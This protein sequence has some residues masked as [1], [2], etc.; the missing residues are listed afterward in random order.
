MKILSPYAYLRPRART[1]G[2]QERIIILEAKGEKQE[3]E[4]DEMD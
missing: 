4:E 2:T 3:E 1:G